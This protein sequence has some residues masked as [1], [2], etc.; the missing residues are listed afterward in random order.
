MAV[1]ISLLRGVNVSGNNIIKMEELRKL[2]ASMGLRDARSYIQSGNVVF[3]TDERDLLALAKLIGDG[4]E[5]KFKC[6]PD[7]I[8]RTTAEMRGAVARNPF[9]KRRDVEPAK[10][11]VTFLAGEPGKEARDK[12]LEIKTDPEEMKILG[13]EIYIHFPNGMGQSKLSWI[14]ITKALKTTGTGRNL[15]SVMKL[16]EMAEELERA[17]E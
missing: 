15:N 7:V 17:G 9:A 12:V 10:L 13:R 3:Q 16:L 5:R 6:R 2:Y 14:A 1:I 8:L 11:L 4:I